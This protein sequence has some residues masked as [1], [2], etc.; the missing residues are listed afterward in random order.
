MEQGAET[1]PERWKE[2]YDQ[3]SETDEDDQFVAG[4]IGELG[5]AEAAL[6]WLIDSPLVPYFI[7]DYARTALGAQSRETQ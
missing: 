2:Y 5:R 1:I 3:L 4:I 6:Q 7:K